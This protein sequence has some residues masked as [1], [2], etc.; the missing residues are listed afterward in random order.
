MDV[1]EEDFVCIHYEAFH[2][3]DWRKQLQL[4]L[5]RGQYLNHVKEAIHQYIEEELLSGPV[6]RAVQGT[7]CAHIT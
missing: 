5:G 1:G 2:I 7:V 4:Y 3:R 6:V